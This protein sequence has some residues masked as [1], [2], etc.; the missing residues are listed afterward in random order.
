MK[1][2]DELM[3]NNQDDFI[4]D[5]VFFYDD[6]GGLTNNPMEIVMVIHQQWFV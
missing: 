2:G 6:S 3:V 1:N 4:L 5:V